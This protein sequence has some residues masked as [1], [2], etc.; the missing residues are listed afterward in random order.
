MITE[1]SWNHLEIL[2]LAARWTL[3][4]TLLA[5]VG[6]TLAGFLVALARTSR[7]P[8]LRLAS[9]VYIQ[10]VQG[11]PVLIVL[12]LS[13]YGLSVLG[14]K[15]SPMVAATLAMSIYA[16]AYLGEIWRGCI[17]AVPPGQWEAGEALALTRWQQLRYVVLPQAV[18]LA[19]PPTVGFSVQLVK[20]TSITS[21]I[22]VIELTRAGQLINNATFQPFAVFVVVAL[23]YFALC[24][25]LSAAARRMERRLHVN[26]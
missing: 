8:L 4:V 12:F 15:L 2:L 21:I 13:Y 1:F 10:V 3:W 7:S 16:S 9:T 23:I 14:L 25:P 24:F 18:R 19:L 26:R 22:G 20:N 5:F 11:T 17:E 6:G